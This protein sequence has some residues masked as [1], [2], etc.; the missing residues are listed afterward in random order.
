MI[1]IKIEEM[2][3]KFLY[4]TLSISKTENLMMFL[5]LCMGGNKML[6]G[7]TDYYAIILVVVFYYFFRKR[8][9]VFSSDFNKW[10]LFF[11]VLFL[12]QFIILKEKSIPADINFLAKFFCA[13][14]GVTIL[15]EKFRYAYFKTITWIALVSLLM[16]LLVLLTHGNIPGIDLERSRSLVVFNYYPNMS[17]L[18]TYRNCGMF[19]EPGAFQGY[20]MLVPLLY[21]GQIKQ[22]WATYRKECL[23]LLVTLLSTV[24]TTGYVTLAAFL[25]LIVLKKVKNLVTR[26]IIIVLMFTGGIY[27]YN[28]FD[29]LGE[30]LE[31]QYAEAQELG[32][33]D[34]TWSR[35]G[36][37]IID[38]DNIKKNPLTGNGFLMKER[39]GNLAE[40]MG[41]TGNGLT[42][43]INIFGVPIIFIYLLSLFKRAP[44]HSDY[45]KVVFTIVVFLMLIGEF[46]LNY[47]PFWSLLFVK[48]PKLCINRAN[49]LF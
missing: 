1:F 39:Y 2:D 42:G 25:F 48:Y 3:R 24:S 20:I 14:L 5:F 26:T 49:K 28:T 23:I 47:P 36:A 9:M 35:F 43:A 40:Y 41:G 17:S 10:L 4:S 13:Y 6:I 19:W 21:I 16:S 31:I 15:G 27:A 38:I 37:T 12:F 22:F 30:K 34:V 11:I 44:T 46:F 45:E 8:N 18:R 32:R 33:G 7:V 29:F